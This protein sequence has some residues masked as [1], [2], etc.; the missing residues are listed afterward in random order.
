MA[1]DV[2]FGG[3]ALATGRVVLFREE[4]GTHLYTAATTLLHLAVAVGA[5][6]G[7]CPMTRSRA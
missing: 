7:L 1:P 5:P 6:P 2:R 4:P 3:P